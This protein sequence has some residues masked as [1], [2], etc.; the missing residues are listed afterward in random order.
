MERTYNSE[1][2]IRRAEEIYQRRKMQGGVRVSTS[3]VNKNRRAEY[4]LFKKLILQILICLLIYFIFYLI[5][6]SNYIFS[7]NVINKTK[8]FL[9]YDINF[10]N[11]FYNVHNFYNEHIA[12]FFKDEDTNNNEINNEQINNEIQENIEQENKG[13]NNNEDVSQEK[14]YWRRRR[15][16]K[17]A[18]KWSTTRSFN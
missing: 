11:M 6:N 13:N 5:H 14:R 9:S 3:N 7:E 12:G 4:K 16:R 2:R 8:E 1:E 10:Q 18:C 17:S 15:G